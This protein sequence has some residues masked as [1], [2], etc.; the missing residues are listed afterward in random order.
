LYYN[1]FVNGLEE[2]LRY[3]DRNSMAHAV[4]V[5]LP[6]LNHE[7]VKFLYTLP[8]NMKIHHGWTKWLLRQSVKDQLPEAIVWRRDKTGFEPP[9]KKWM[10]EPQ[11]QEA[12]RRG[13]QVLADHGILN[14]TALAQ[15]LKPHEA[16]AAESWDWR[17]WTASYLF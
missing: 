8:P 12:I 3:A 15:K 16:H 14:T 10:S 5:R 11:V 4:E 7:L 6:F 2:L 9:Q 17:Y 1:T 13:K